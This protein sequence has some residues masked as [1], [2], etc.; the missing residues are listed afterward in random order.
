MLTDL[1]VIGAKVIGAKPRLAFVIPSQDA[2]ML[3]APTPL[4]GAAIGISDP[5]KQGLTFRPIPGSAVC[6]KKK[7]EPHP[8]TQLVKSG[9]E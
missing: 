5:G 6:K 4:L 1:I 8:R 3:C 7:Q 9:R 2:A